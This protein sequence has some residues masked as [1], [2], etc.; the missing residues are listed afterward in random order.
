MSTISLSAEVYGTYARF[1]AVADFLELYVLRVPSRVV[2]QPDLERQIEKED[3]RLSSPLGPNP[4]DAAQAAAVVF[5]IFEERARILGDRYPFLV[6]KQKGL[7]AKSR[8]VGLYRVL[9]ALTAAHAYG[10]VSGSPAKV[11]ES[12]VARALRTTG[13]RTAHTGTARTRDQRGF[14]GMLTDACG[15]VGLIASPDAALLSS[16][17][18]DEKVDTL[19]HLD[20]GDGRPGRWTYIG[21]ATVAESS[22]WEAKAAEPKPKLWK[23]LITDTHAP[24]PFLAVPYHVEENHLRSLH[25]RLP[26][27]VLDRLRLSRAGM[28]PSTT[29]RAI[30]ETVAECRV[31]W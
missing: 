18:Q 6:D 19:A 15:E 29:E 23:R 25:E 20:L 31:E 12:L 9:L 7:R 10:V 24:S 14:G 8:R 5:G 30:V 2:Q 13:L 16:A 27:I 3:I 28:Q 26:S 1:S 17:A 4:S 11:F 21:Q 22:S